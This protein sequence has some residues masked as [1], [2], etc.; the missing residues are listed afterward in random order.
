MK[1]EEKQEGVTMYKEI[2]NEEE[3]R[4]KEGRGREREEREREK[5]EGEKLNGSQSHITFPQWPSAPSQKP[6]AHYK[7]KEMLPDDAG[8]KEARW[9]EEGGR[10]GGREG[11]S[12]GREV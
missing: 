3:K 6:F 11:L 9:N 4:R 8:M 2:T 7:K 12:K 1:T 5:R 10:E